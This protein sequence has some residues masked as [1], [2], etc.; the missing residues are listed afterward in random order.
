MKPNAKWDRDSFPEFLSVLYWMRQA[1]SVA[2][3]ACLGL[4][5]VTGFLGFVLFLVANT[6]LPFVYYK[7]YANIDIDDFGHNE[8]LSEGY[9]PSFGM[10]LLMWIVAYS[11]NH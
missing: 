9:Q 7:H 4:W 11:I 10:F 3:G 2:L 8:V 5:G 6:F 1:I